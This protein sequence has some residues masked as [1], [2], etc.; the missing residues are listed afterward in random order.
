M[1]T[2]FLRVWKEVNIEQI[3]DHIAV[4]GMKSAICQ[5]CKNNIADLSN[6]ECDNCGTKIQYLAFRQEIVE[7]PSFFAKLKVWQDKFICIDFK[8]FSS[9]A[10]RMKAHDIFKKEN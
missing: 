1:S 10:A 6:C 2:K 3:K 8:D 7:D 4:L 9:M 5:K